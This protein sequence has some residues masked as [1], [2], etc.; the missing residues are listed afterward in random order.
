MKIVY[1]V[2][3]MK[4]YVWARSGLQIDFDLPSNQRKKR[5]GDKIHNSVT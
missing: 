4:F 2:Q 3:A 5:I 1:Q